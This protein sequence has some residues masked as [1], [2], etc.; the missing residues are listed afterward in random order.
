MAPTSESAGPARPLTVGSAPRSLMRVGI[1][2]VGVLALLM[3]VSALAYTGVGL[4]TL[5]REE[6]THD[7]PADLE[8]LTVNADSATVE[9]ESRDDI[10]APL[11]RHTYRGAD[12]QKST[13]AITGDEG[14]A[15]VSIP[16]A[17]GSYRWWTPNVG[18]EN[19]VT[20]ELPSDQARTMDLDVMSDFGFTELVG[21]FND[22]RVQT[23]AGAMV[24]D[25]EASTVEAR[26]RT[27]F[28]DV[29]GAMD[30]LSMEATAG[31][32]DGS[33]L[34]VAE[35]VTARTTTGGIE[36]G[37]S[38]TVVPVQGIEAHAQNG[39]VTVSLPREENL[40]DQD[41]TGY[42]VNAGSSAG[43][44]DVAVQQTPPGDGVVPVTV[45][46]DSGSVNVQYRDGSDGA[47]G[48]DTDDDWDDDWEDDWE[49]GWDDDQ[50]DRGGD[51]D[52]GGE[53]DR[54]SDQDGQDADRDSDE[55]S[56][57][58]ADRDSEGGSESAA[59]DAGRV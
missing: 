10:D 42:S 56:D 6:T 37:F 52:S 28:L 13:P 15:T 12:T 16:R 20:I 55:V 40:V 58:D 29:S 57:Q 33:H 23:Q 30:S 39:A 9:V 44:T 14:T 48:A 24:L 50:D 49:D 54:D 25:L 5:V 11:V 8:A 32:I 47:R 35:T 41:V 59:S 27:G 18:M 26:T 17:P 51:R 19:T 38:G 31:Y 21:E 22:V 53:S 45:S 36:L 43:W 2:V 34:E 46:S 1:A 4:S 3:P 7:L